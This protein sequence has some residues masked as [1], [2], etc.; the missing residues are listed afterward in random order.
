MRMGWVGPVRIFR[1]QAQ[2]TNGQDARVQI[3]VQVVQSQRI[4]VN[5]SKSKEMVT[6][7]FCHFM[8]KISSL[9][10]SSALV[11]FIFSIFCLVHTQLRNRLRNEKAEKLVMCHCTLR[12]ENC[13]WL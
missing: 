3:Q 6:P 9:H 13:D 8:T 4:K 11:E 5:Q 12:D 1:T 7:E 2:D 10:E